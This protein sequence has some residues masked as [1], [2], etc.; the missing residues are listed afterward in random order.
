MTTATDGVVRIWDIKTSDTRYENGHSAPGTKVVVDPARRNSA[1]TVGRDGTIDV[2]DLETG[3]RVLA[4]KGHVN[5]IFDASFSSTGE[6]LV[7]ASRDKTARIW[8]IPAAT[9]TP[10]RTNVGAQTRTI[11]ID[12]KAKLVALGSS[13]GT[14]ALLETGTFRRLASAKISQRAV[15]LVKFNEQANQVLLGSEDGSVALYSI[16]KLERLYSGST[17]NS[18]IGGGYFTETGFSVLTLGG[19]T[20]AYDGKTLTQIRHHNY[21]SAS[22]IVPARGDRALVAE[23][24]GAARIIDN[25]ERQN[26]RRTPGSRRDYRACRVRPWWKHRRNRVRGRDGH[27]L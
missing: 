27:R 14:V 23:T 5:A 15:T 13:D 26:D 8:R 6:Y 9:T 2:W 17:D 20:Y 22:T 18:E 3:A 24:S 7:T 25:P 19:G 16:P 12:D 10:N 21:D 11:D 1:V 4:L